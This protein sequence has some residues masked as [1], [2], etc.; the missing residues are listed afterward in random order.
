MRTRSSVAVKFFGVLALAWGIRGLYKA[1]VYFAGKPWTEFELSWTQ[2]LLSSDA[3]LLVLIPVCL[4]ASGTGLLRGKPWARCLL[5]T[6]TAILVILLAG[7]L[8]V[9]GPCTEE[10]RYVVGFGMAGFVIWFFNQPTIRSMYPPV[11][12]MRILAMVWVMTL[13]SGLFWATISWFR[14]G[15][16]ESPRLEKTVYQY[17]GDDVFARDYVR[18]PFPLMYTLVIPKEFVVRSLTKDDSGSIDIWLA[19]PEGRGLIALGSSPWFDYLF[20][21]SG[22]LP[23]DGDAYRSTRKLFAERYGLI[24]RLVRKLGIVGNASRFEEARIDGV[25]A[26]IARSL[27]ETAS[28][29][30]YLFQE[31][32]PIG[33]G[34]IVAPKEGYSLSIEQVDDVISS[35]KPQDEPPRSAEEYFQEGVALFDAG[36]VEGAKFSFASALCLEWENAECHYYLAR[37]FL[38]TDNAKSGWEHLK[39]AMSLDPDC[40]EAQELLEW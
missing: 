13:L 19:T 39:E 1:V 36:D 27:G 28:I 33:A 6:T 2:W 15:G 4:I 29:E 11:K 17:K 12:G 38:E 9:I 40:P 22:A 35:I 23:K 14:E 32:Q 10:I 5:L 30:Y 21:L 26:F 20:P 3:T 25:T 8:I 7:R 16:P 34:S 24:P 31:R 18:S 37:A